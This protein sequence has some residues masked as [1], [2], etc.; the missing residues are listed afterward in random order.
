MNSNIMQQS[1]EIQNKL[2]KFEVY[3]QF[4]MRMFKPPTF[5]KLTIIIGLVILIISLGLIA[6]AFY[7][8]NKSRNH[9]P[10]V[11]E[12]PD[13][14]ESTG[15]NKCSNVKNLG[16]CTDKDYDFS[17]PEYRGNRGKKAKFELAKQCGWEWDGITNDAE[18]LDVTTNMIPE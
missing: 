10:D 15:K 6:T 1:M 18:F 5:Q 9:P 13:Y 16:T 8:M 7:S 12:C 2:F 11:A 3:K 14:F 17:T 4:F